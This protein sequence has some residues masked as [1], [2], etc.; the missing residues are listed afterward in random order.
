LLDAIA[1]RGPRRGVVFEQFDREYEPML[2]QLMAKTGVDAEDVAAAV[3]F[4]RKGWNW[5]FYKPLVEIALRHGMT[6]HAGNLSREAAAQ[7][8]RRGMAAL[9]PAAIAALR[10]DDGWSEARERALREIIAQGHCGAL[11]DTAVRPMTLAQRA[12][13]ATLAQALLSVDRER[14]VL[15]AGNGHVRRDL[16][17][18]VYLSA[19]AAGKASCAL[20]ILE[21]EAGHRDPRAYLHSA[22]SDAHRYDFAFF[23]PRWERPDPCDAFRR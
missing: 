17:V 5:T 15:I 20:G 12:R 23:T 2:Q 13:D 10:L 6:L 1:A 4:N 8:A 9:E 21:V 22:A 19:A 18:P 7:I 3:R 16:A 14:A 11:P